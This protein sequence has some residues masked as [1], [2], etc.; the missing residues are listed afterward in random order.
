[1][2]NAGDLLREM[3]DRGIGFFAG[4]PDSLLAPFCAS[5]ARLPRSEHVIAANEGAAIGLA[6]GHYLARGAVPLVYM[7]NSGLGNAVN[8]LTSLADPEVYGVPLV[9]LIGWRGA[10]GEP[11]EPQHAKQGRIT[12]DLL[13]VLEIPYQVLDGDCAEPAALVRRALAVARRRSGPSAIVVRRGAFAPHTPSMAAPRFP[14]KREEAIAA[15]L[16]G[17]DPNSPIVATTGMIGRELFE[18]RSRTGAGHARDFLCVGG[19]GH[20]SQVALGL[21]LARPGRK[22]VCLDGDGAALMHL[23]GLAT[24]GASGASILHVVL[25]NGQHGSVGGQPTVALEIDL[26]GAARALGYAEASRVETAAELGGALVD[27]RSTTGPALLEVRVAPG[28][29]ADLGRPTIWP[30]DAKRR[31][32][33]A[34]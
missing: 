34:L 27:V 10:P 20:A 15:L 26:P 21:A 12:P 31:F 17:L 9:L 32:M 30:Q 24:I 6:I 11:D 23:G 19:M 3:L 22:I 14:L 2:L 18:L 1:M 25:N 33:E 8:P 16:A 13:D 28:E 7:Q 29:R 5:L 4:V